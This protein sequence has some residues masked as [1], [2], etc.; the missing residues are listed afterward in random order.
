MVGTFPLI[1]WTPGRRTE[2][3]R[4]K[5]KTS[6]S[7]FFFRQRSSFST[8]FLIQSLTHTDWRNNNFARWNS[9]RHASQQFEKLTTYSAPAVFYS[10]SISHLNRRCNLSKTCLLFLPR[11]V[12]PFFSLRSDRHM[13]QDR[14]FFS[15][16]MEE[17]I[18]FQSPGQNI[19]GVCI[20]RTASVVLSI[21]LFLSREKYRIFFAESQE[22]GAVV[23]SSIVWGL[24]FLPIISITWSSLSPTGWSTYCVCNH[25]PKN[26]PFRN[27]QWTRSTFKSTK[28]TMTKWLDFLSGNGSI[29]RTA[30]WIGYLKSEPS[31]RV[32]LYLM[33]RG[34]AVYRAIESVDR[35]CSCRQFFRVMKRISWQEN[36]LTYSYACDAHRDNDG[37]FWDA[38]V[39]FSSTG[40]DDDKRDGVD[41]W[42][43]SPV[44]RIGCDQQ[45][46]GRRIGRSSASKG[47]FTGDCW[48][49]A[50]SWWMQ[51][52]LR[53]VNRRRMKGRFVTTAQLCYEWRVKVAGEED[54]SKEL[55]KSDRIE[56]QG[57]KD[58]SLLYVI[59]FSPKAEGSSSKAVKYVTRENCEREREREKE[60]CQKERR[61][62]RKERRAARKRRWRLVCLWPASSS[63]P[64][65]P[66]H[67]LCFS[68]PET[69]TRDRHPQPTSFR[70]P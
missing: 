69:M 64:V 65:C 60:R 5:G 58:P 48:P 18:Y 68:P 25:S 24:A 39:R 67:P 32:T 66:P 63:P 12:M 14:S 16:Y 53:C 20:S 27:S 37:Y 59:G 50:F 49:I 2:T 10:R 41:R 6:S 7:L 13:E 52:I 26:C 70:Y 62:R 38:K 15:E 45:I 46:T 40:A 29:T 28:K 17:K 34:S 4:P 54:A 9:E 3:Y 23:C 33:S 55:R 11:D 56:M 57:E 1:Q 36:L 35:D 31:V 61:R 22:A 8:L 43:G 44:L 51:G 19:D 21:L 47:W 30:S 42:S